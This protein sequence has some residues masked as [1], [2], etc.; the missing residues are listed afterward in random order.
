MKYLTGLIFLVLASTSAFADHHALNLEAR[1]PRSDLEI[2]SIQL[3]EDL[4]VITA[5]GASGE[6]GK[7]YVTYSPVIR[8]RWLWWLVHSAWPRLC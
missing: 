4:S 2:T 5:E 7:V 3:G 6:Y 1:Q 8:Q